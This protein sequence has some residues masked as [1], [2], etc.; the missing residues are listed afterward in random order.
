MTEVMRVVDMMQ[1]TIRKHV[2][3][4]M[5]HRTNAIL[6]LGLCG[7]AWVRRKKRAASLRS[8]W[9]KETQRDESGGSA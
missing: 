6:R 3:V 2:G 4:G 8:V 7:D 1:L 9:Q 5:M